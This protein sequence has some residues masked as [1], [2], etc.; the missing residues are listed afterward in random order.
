MAIEN[1]D[2]ATVTG[3]SALALVL[4]GYARKFYMDWMKGRPE[5]AASGAMDAQFKVLREQLEAIQRDN[6][7]LRNAFNSMDVKL[8]RQQTKLTR[9]EMLVRQFVGLVKEHGIPV[10]KYMQEELDDLL[11]E[12]KEQ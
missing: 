6:T 3:G 5:I 10:P 2:P 4:A 7:D 8:H 9:T 12:D 1:F 11:K